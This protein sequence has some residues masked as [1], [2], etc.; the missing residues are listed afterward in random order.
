M[1]VFNV[2]FN[3]DFITQ[4]FDLNVFET[5]LTQS[6]SLSLLVVIICH[7]LNPLSSH[8]VAMA[9][10]QP[11]PVVMVTNQSVLRMGGTL[12]VLNM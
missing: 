4:T 3:L 2:T 10:V 11:L 7:Y 12:E 6:L 9:K 1:C 5:M 8:Y